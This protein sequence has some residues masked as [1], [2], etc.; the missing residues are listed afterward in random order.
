MNSSTESEFFR[1][2]LTDHLQSV[3][4]SEKEYDNA[5]IVAERLMLESKVSHDE[6]LEMVRQANAA[7]CRHLG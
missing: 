5:L 4:L 3:V 6:W 1:I 7:L 2:W